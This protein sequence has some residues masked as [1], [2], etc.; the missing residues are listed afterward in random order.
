MNNII[1]TFQRFLKNKNTVTIIGVV[2]VIGILYWGYNMQIGLLGIIQAFEHGCHNVSEA[3]EFLNV[4][5]NYFINAVK[6]YRQKYGIYV[7]ID[8]Y[9]IIF[10]PTLAVYKSL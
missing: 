9:T 2:A 5:E 8:N 4:T 7:A 6:C 10:D 1:V 3:A